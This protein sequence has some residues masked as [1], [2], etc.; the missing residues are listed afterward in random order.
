LSA[1]AL[2][3]LACR[4]VISGDVP[5]LG[6]G[7][8]AGATP[9]TAGSSGSGQA[10]IPGTTPPDTFETIPPGA[11]FSPLRPEQAVAKVKNLLTGSTATDEE[12]AAVRADESGLKGLI[13]AWLTTPEAEHKLR[14]FFQVAFQQG[15]IVDK[16]LNDQLACDFHSLA[17]PDASLTRAL[18]KNVEESF[19]RTALHIALSNQPFSD[20]VTTRQY[21]LTPGLAGLLAYL[22]YH[23]VDD[24]KQFRGDSAF[25]LEFQ[26]Y[27]A[28]GPI[29]WAEQVA[30]RR[31]YTKDANLGQVLAD[32]LTS[33][34]PFQLYLY[35][36]GIVLGSSL[37]F[38][39][40]RFTASDMQEWK[41]YTI[42]Q[43]AP[44]ESPTAFW[45]VEALRGA[46]ELVLSL[47]RV[48]FFTTPAFFAT[49]QTN[50]SNQHRLT[51]N[52]TLIV[53]LGSSFI[54]QAGAIPVREVS[55]DA[56][57]ASQ[58]ECQGCH[59][60]LDP[61]R[62]YFRQAYS[63]AGSHQRDSK[64][65]GQ[66]G[67]F[68]FSGE[69]HDGGDLYDFAET[70]AKHPQF[71][72]AWAQKL[73]QWAN[74]S[75]CLADDPELLRVVELFRQSQL[76]FKTLVRE[77]FSSPLVTWRSRTATSDAQGQLVSIARYGHFCRALEHR[78]GVVDPCGNADPNSSAHAVSVSIPADA[79][80]RGKPEPILP[81]ESNLFQRSAVEALCSRVADAVVDTSGLP[82]TVATTDVAQALATLVRVVMNIDDG[83]PRRARLLAILQKHFDAARA[84]GA[85][86]KAALAS[87][88]TLAC[89]SPTSAGVGL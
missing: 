55:L 22:D 17:S 39:E 72:I 11:P 29:P 2:S 53:A 60:R 66:Q 75:P 70:L 85:T 36:M 35:L 57:H 24:D 9:N 86:P 19:S 50:D 40:P 54:P 42:R 43:P 27:H 76:S 77:L 21:Y 48:G 88:F 44:G 52:Q 69:V 37:N 6:G 30:G 34:N 5:T 68:A 38:P 28:A 20:V 65:S 59:V 82:V 78:L 46:N 62:A 18:L 71:A 89:S 13:D 12:L 33:K 73:C 79:F 45:D 74:S 26:L 51:T 23:V 47:P 15:P 81:T 1:L 32:P 64:W 58:L 49:W 10:G 80:S 84:G 16:S 8:G 14:D 61:M 3:G 31:F 83:D 41:L 56:A 4:A 87:T 67:S 7:G 25:P 63:L